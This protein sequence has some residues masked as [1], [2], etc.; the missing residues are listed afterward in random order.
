MSNFICEQCDAPALWKVQPVSRKGGYDLVPSYY[1]S[2]CVPPWV[3]KMYRLG[4]T[5]AHVKISKLAEKGTLQIGKECQ[6]IRN[7][8]PFDRRWTKIRWTI[9][10]VLEPLPGRENL[11]RVEVSTDDPYVATHDQK[12]IVTEDWVQVLR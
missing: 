8:Q 10:G 1:C 11:L 4:G 5:A 7:G 3:D 12:K 2:E 9:M 6:L